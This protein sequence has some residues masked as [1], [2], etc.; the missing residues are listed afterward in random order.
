MKR[1]EKNSEAFVQY[2][3]SADVAAR[4]AT[5]GLTVTKVRSLSL[6]DMVNKFSVTEAE[7]NEIKDAVQRQPIEKETLYTRL[8]RSNY[9]CNICHGVIKGTSFVACLSGLHP[10]PLGLVLAMDVLAREDLPFPQSLPEFQRI[11][12]D[13]A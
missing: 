10:H 8:E 12:P 9:T 7:A 6:G 11:F 5:S 1:L 3:I 4:A 13:D 2:G